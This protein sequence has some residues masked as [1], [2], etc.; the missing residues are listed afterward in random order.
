MMKMVHFFE[1]ND[2]CNIQL[3][4]NNEKKIDIKCHFIKTDC[5]SD[6]LLHPDGNKV[7][8]NLY[9]LGIYIGDP[10]TIDDMLR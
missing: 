6:D 10:Y 2:H 1:L 3:Y 5:K 8:D 4:I 9:Y 7:C